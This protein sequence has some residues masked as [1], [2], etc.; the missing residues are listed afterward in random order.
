MA[1]SVQPTPI[2]QQARFQEEVRQTGF[3]M[4]LSLILGVLMLVGKVTAYLA[5]WIDGHTLGRG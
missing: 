2:T 5:D 4:R 3:A 1:A